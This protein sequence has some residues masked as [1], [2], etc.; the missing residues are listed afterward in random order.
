VF[1]G[2]RAIEGVRLAD[3]CPC[4]R[5]FRGSDG[6]GKECECP[7]E[8]QI[9]RGWSLL[10]NR[11]ERR[12][13]FWVGLIMRICGV[14]YMCTAFENGFDGWIHSYGGLCLFRG[15]G[16]TGG[17]DNVSLSL[18]ILLCTESDRGSEQE[19]EWGVCRIGLGF[20]LCAVP[21]RYYMSEYFGVS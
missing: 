18:N 12:T 11:L 10:G 21:L 19:P 7:C 3:L 2:V 5:Y 17:H 14:L 8:F 15:S 1:T 20:S 4:L 13:A 9:Q 16:G 6:V